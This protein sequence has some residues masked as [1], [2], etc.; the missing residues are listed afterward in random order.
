[1]HFGLETRMPFLDYKIYEFSKSLPNNFKINKGEQKII[2]K[3]LLERYLPLELFQRPK[4]GFI[5]PI[6]DIIEYNIDFIENLFKDD[7]VLQ[8]SQ[9]NHKLT[10]KELES[11]KKG[12]Y[13]NQYNLWDLIVFHL[14]LKNNIGNI[15]E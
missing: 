6:T 9:I 2:L 15:I 14:W 7:Q 8:L 1:M 3:R 4:Q 12:D 13:S 11:F 10:I 5:S